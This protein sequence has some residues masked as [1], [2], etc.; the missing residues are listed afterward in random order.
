MPP[1]FPAFLAET[2]RIQS[3]EGSWIDAYCARPLGPGP[4]PA[5]VIVHH[6]PG[7]DEEGW[8]HRRHS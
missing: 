3:A 1:M 2:V 6:A 4:Y 5:V 7:L 8:K